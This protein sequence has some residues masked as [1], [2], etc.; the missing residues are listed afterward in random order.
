VGGGAGWG[1]V[2]GAVW[3]AAEQR[4]A[5][6]ATVISELTAVVKDQRARLAARERDGGGGG[7]AESRREAEREGRRRRE[8][9]AEAARLAAECDA[10]RDEVRG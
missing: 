10:L 5:R 6:A 2:A 8:A 4:E 9:E 1:S 7:G 3:Q